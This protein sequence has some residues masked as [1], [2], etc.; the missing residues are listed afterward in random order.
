VP[1]GDVPEPYR[2][3]TS[4]GQTVIEPP[5]HPDYKPA[6]PVD[7]PV[8]PTAPPT[9]YGIWSWLVFGGGTA[10]LVGS[11]VAAL[12]VLG[13]ER[14]EAAQVGEPVGEVRVNA[15]GDS[16][17]CEA[18]D[19]WK[20][21]E[22]EAEQARKRMAKAAQALLLAEK[23]R[24]RAASAAAG[25]KS[26]LEALTLLWRGKVDSAR[27][28]WLSKIAQ[29]EETF[30]E[31]ESR[32]RKEFALGPPNP[33]EKTEGATRV[34]GEVESV[35][36]KLEAYR[37]RSYPGSVAFQVENWGRFTAY[38]TAD[39]RVRLVNRDVPPKDL[40][41][42]QSATFY[43]YPVVKEIVTIWCPR[44]PV[45]ERR[46]AAELAKVRSARTAAVDALKAKMTEEVASLQ[47]EREKALRAARRL[48]EEA[49][50]AEM[51]AVA[52]VRA[53][54][55]ASRLADA[56]AEAANTAAQKSHARHDAIVAVM[57]AYA[58]F[59]EPWRGK[60]VERWAKAYRAAP[61]KDLRD[62]L[63]TT[64]P[65]W[66]GELGAPDTWE[67]GDYGTRLH[68]ARIL[69]VAP[70]NHL[71][72]DYWEGVTPGSKSCHSVVVLK[73]TSTEGL[74]D[75]RRFGSFGAFIH[76]YGTTVYRTSGWSSS[77]TWW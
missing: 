24:G 31:Q 12:L 44:D 15:L 42:G 21:A 13:G 34:V 63:F 4:R 27:Q 60:F 46:L 71:L 8:A 72:V 57:N 45:R 37:D 64:D 16:L 76:V 20:R 55:E 29:A 30:G 51:K 10:S 66:L 59:A 49:E 43:Y 61:A 69:R 14:R 50:R 35:S 19:V 25:E 62:K 74:V 67:V 1:F 41:V 23:S 26:N 6:A 7:A 28:S 11:I 17:S 22:A 38:L 68:N 75:D 65:L 2:G 33:F 39:T 52:R 77:R 9:R 53:A 36:L 56:S 3:V 32:V 48:L 40:V 54:G 58:Q 47:A 70:P 5:F 73:V 18:R